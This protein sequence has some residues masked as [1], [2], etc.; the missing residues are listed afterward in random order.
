MSTIKPELAE[1]LA[2]VTK[3]NAVMTPITMREG[4]TLTAKMQELPKVPLARI[5]DTVLD[6]CGEYDV[7]VRIYLPVEN[8]PLKVVIFYHGGGFAVSNVSDYDIVCRRLA[9]AANA[10]VISPEYRLAPENKYPAANIDA[11]ATARR[12]FPKLDKLGIPYQEDL[13]VSGDSAGGYLATVVSQALQDDPSLPLTHQLLIY[14]CLDFTCSY[15][16]IQENANVQTGFTKEKLRW[17]FDAYFHTDDDRKAASTLF[18]KLTANMP[19]TL[20]ITTDFCP[21]RDEALA[22]ARRLQE[23]G[24]RVETHKYDNVVHRY[25]NFE[26]TCYDEICDTYARMAAFLNA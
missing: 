4:S 24:V 16:S 22:Y 14:P 7:P 3:E 25:I 5:V 11:L 15:P 23:K 9:K 18:G 12:I 13:S 19:A 26:K 21:F 2:S 1:F 20:V 10:I 6:N 17:Y 8:Q